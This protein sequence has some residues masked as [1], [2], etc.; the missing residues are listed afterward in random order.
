MTI[1]VGEYD[2]EK[3]AEEKRKADALEGDN[4]SSGPSSSQDAN[5]PKLT[6][7]NLLQLQL[8]PI[9]RHNSGVDWPQSG[10]SSARTSKKSSSESSR[11]GSSG[12]RKKNRSRSVLNP[13]TKAPPFVPRRTTV[14]PKSC[15]VLK[16]VTTKKPPTVEYFG[17]TKI[18]SVYAKLAQLLFLVPSDFFAEISNFDAALEYAEKVCIIITLRT[19]MDIEHSSFFF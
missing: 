8:A 1:Y 15:T 10:K 7:S 19:R 11:P 16:E 14:A 17:S 5:L 4:N 3:A 12:S 2:N 9:S 18:A 13:K 6:K